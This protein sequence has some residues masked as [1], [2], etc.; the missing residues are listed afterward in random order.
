MMALTVHSYHA[1]YIGIT[2]T[3]LREGIIVSTERHIRDDIVKF[4]HI[5]FK[6]VG[7]V[8]QSYVPINPCTDDRVAGSGYKN[9]S[10]CNFRPL[11]DNAQKYITD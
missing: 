7:A 10:R 3:C 2:A 8:A 6:G 4:S 11:I 1:G 5:V 9:R